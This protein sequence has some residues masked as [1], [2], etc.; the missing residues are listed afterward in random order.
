MITRNFSKSPLRSLF[1][2]LFFSLSEKSL[3]HPY[4][5]EFVAPGT[6]AE[7]AKSCATFFE[8]V[9]YPP[10][11]GLFGVCWD[12]SKIT[13]RAELDPRTGKFLNSVSF[14]TDLSF[15]TYADYQK[16]QKEKV[17]AG[18][19]MPILL[20]PLDPA[21]SSSFRV[22]GLIPTNL[23][24]TAADLS[25]YRH[26]HP[27]APAR[28]RPHPPAPATAP[29]PE[30]ERERETAPTLTLNPSRRSPSTSQPPT[31]ST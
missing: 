17:L 5:K 25:G 22:V 3:K 16:F 24:Y 8:S 26:V 23:K 10:S 28:T 2:K 14:N 21:L 20:V 13:A 18:Y 19:V 9:G 4:R 29:A 1:N 15:G 12:P 27:P 6:S 11:T 7:Y 31:S 30:R